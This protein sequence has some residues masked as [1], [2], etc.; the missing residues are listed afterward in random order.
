MPSPAAAKLLNKLKGIKQKSNGGWTSFCPGHNDTNNRSL[1]IDERAG[2]ILVK[3]FLS[4]DVNTILAAIGMTSA[5]LFS[6]AGN[7]YQGTRQKPPES[8]HNKP[9]CKRTVYEIRPIAYQPP[10][11]LHV[12]TDFDDGTKTFHWEAN[13]KMGLGDL[14]LVDLPLYGA[15]EIPD[16]APFIIVCEGEKARDALSAKGY[17]AVSVYGAEA[18][19]SL[20]RLREISHHA[21][22]LFPDNDLAG[23]R[24]MDKIA[25][26]LT[27]LN[28][29]PLII[30]WV[31][32]PIKGDA[33]DY[34]A[35]GLNVDDLLGEAKLWEDS[36]I[37]GDSGKTEK[38]K[39]VAG[40]WKGW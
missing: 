34:V 6:D 5:D 7:S 26:L 13:G 16:E 15:W 24:C 33:F 27:S 17:H 8:Q 35:L 39:P 21:V 11:A 38:A 23:A 1:S 29:P 10:I 40:Q 3:C 20:E 31:Q 36:Y 22:F 2:R 28:C 32:A 30:Q 4:C 37:F 19:P 25:S 18:I 14:K 12:R 9:G